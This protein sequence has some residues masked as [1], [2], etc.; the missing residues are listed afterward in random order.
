MFGVQGGEESKSSLICLAFKEE[1]SQ[2][3]ATG[4]FSYVWRRR[5]RKRRVKEQRLDIS[6]MF[7]VQGSECIYYKTRHMHFAFTHTTEQRKW[8]QRHK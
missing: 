4:Y 6:H 2:R 8:I 1:K 7:G 5:P 3:A